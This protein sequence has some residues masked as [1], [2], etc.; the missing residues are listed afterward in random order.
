MNNTPAT[1]SP[2]PNTGNGEPN[3]DHG[4]KALVSPCIVIALITSPMKV[5]TSNK[6]AT[7][8][9]DREMKQLSIVIIRTATVTAASPLAPRPKVANTRRTKK[10]ISPVLINSAAN[11]NIMT[12]R[13]CPVADNVI[14]P[15]FR[16]AVISD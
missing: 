9:R 5:T 11:L 6:P 13:F 14:I 8:S 10:A 2:E 12:E 16:Q 15:P 3:V 7:N 4:Q 1:G